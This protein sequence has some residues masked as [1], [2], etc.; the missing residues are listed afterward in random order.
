MYTNYTYVYTDIWKQAE[1]FAEKERP[2]RPTTRINGHRVGGGGGLG[3][4]GPGSRHI[5]AARPIYVALW[6][7]LR[8]DFEQVAQESKFPPAI[9]KYIL[10]STT[11]HGTV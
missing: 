2:T 1:I 7:T 4:H 5:Q 9:C 11:A 3:I 10:T 6:S 8:H